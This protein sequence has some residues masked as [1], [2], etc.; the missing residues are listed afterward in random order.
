MYLDGV[1]ED[2]QRITGAWKEDADGL[3]TFVSQPAGLPAH[4]NDNLKDWPFL[5]Y[6]WRIYHRILQA[7]VP[8]FR[9]SNSKLS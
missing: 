9:Q 5:R 2:D 1:K 4:L 8:R 7:V 3:L 6:C